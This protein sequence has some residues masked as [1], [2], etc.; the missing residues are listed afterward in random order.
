M[1]IEQVMRNID[2]GSAYKLFHDDVEVDEHGNEVEG[3]EAAEGGVAAPEAPAADLQTPQIDYVALAKAEIE[4]QEVQKKDNQ[5]ELMGDMADIFKEEGTNAVL[6]DDLA[7]QLEDKGHNVRVVGGKE[8]VNANGNEVRT[9]ATL[10]ITRPDGETIRMKDTNGDGAIGMEDRDFE[11]LMGEY[12]KGTLDEISKL[13]D[14]EN[15]N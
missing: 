6:I 7:A 12:D 1:A 10:E 11:K 8:E 2:V 5:N 15:T 13:A 3:E 14:N 4:A 9:G